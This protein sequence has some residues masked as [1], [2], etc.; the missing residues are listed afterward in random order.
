VSR[1]PVDAPAQL[2]QAAGR[3]VCVQVSPIE[4]A[5]QTWGPVRACFRRALDGWTLVGIDR[6]LA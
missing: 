6:S 5:Y 2:P 1:A 3:F 4:P